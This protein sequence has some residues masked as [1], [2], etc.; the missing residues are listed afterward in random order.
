M[1]KHILGEIKGKNAFPLGIV[2]TVI[3][4]ME[5]MQRVHKTGALL[6]LPKFFREVA[7]VLWKIVKGKIK[8]KAFSLFS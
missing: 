2:S 5:A 6:D 3:S 1:T 4:F 7:E 8:D